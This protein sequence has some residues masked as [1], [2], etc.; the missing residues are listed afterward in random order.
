M[1]NT[2]VSLTSIPSRFKYLPA[3]VQQL[4]RQN[5]PVWVNIPHVYNRFPHEEVIIPEI[6]NCVINR[7]KDY[8]PATK[9]LGPIDGGCNA[10][11]IIVV[12]DDTAYPSNMTS[13]YTELI[14][15]EPVCWCS[16]GF[17]LDEYF[18]NNGIVGRYHSEKVDVAE[19]YG[20]VILKRIWIENIKSDVESLLDIAHNAD[21]IVVSNMVHK[22]GIDIKTVCDQSFNIGMIRQYDFGMGTDA[23]W[24]IE[25]D[26]HLPKYKRIINLFK[27]RSQMHF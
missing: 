2:I 27:E 13:V 15:H 10:D 21:D 22:N 12:D 18:N 7:C 4:N 23:L 17:R 16:S 8:G 19:G 3:I 11:N 14:N 25:E 20:G 24:R 1:D 5:V 26:G 9:Y 6:N